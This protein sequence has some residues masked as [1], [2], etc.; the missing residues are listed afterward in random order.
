MGKE[1]A[2]FMT[3]VHIEDVLHFRVRLVYRSQY[4]WEDSHGNCPDCS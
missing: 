4:G 3:I 1:S 2:L